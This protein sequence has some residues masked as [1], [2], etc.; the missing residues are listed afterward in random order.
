[1]NRNV[2]LLCLAEALYVCYLSIGFT[3][4]SLVG[5]ALATDKNLATLPFSLTIV[6]SAVTTIAASMLMARVGRRLGFM[7]GAMIGVAGGALATFAIIGGSFWLFCAGNFLMGM[8]KAFAQYYRFA[9]GEVT[10]PEKR[11]SAISLV[12]AGGVIAAVGGPQ[13]AAFSR[14]LLAPA[15]FAGSFAAITVLALATFALTAFLQVPPVARVGRSQGGRPLAE[16]MKTPPFITAVAAGS[17]GYS[18]M[19]FVMTATPLAVI[20]CGYSI[21]DAATVIQWHLL[22]M[23][24]PS[25]LTGRLTARIGTLTVILIGAALL[26]ASAAIGVSGTSLVHFWVGLLAS[27]VGWNFMYVGATILLTEN[28][29]PEERAKVQAANEFIMFACVSLSTF[30]AGAFYNLY[31]WTAV[32]LLGVPPVI[33]VL[34]LIVWLMARRRPAAVSA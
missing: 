2:I 10:E 22:G 27:G 23:F 28:H 31:G 34:G 16:I 30:I 4:I 19:G 26:L 32:A 12:L 24:A 8:F 18:V 13:L 15:A 17:V 29:A 33:L 25:F 3:L 14:D 20:G 5:Q 11:A 6:A 7:V 21:G 9:A 1:M